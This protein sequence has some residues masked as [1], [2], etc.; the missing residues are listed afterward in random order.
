MK[1]SL[2]GGLLTSFLWFVATVMA[3]MQ[4]LE[5][6]AIWAVV[7][8]LLIALVFLYSKRASI[9]CISAQGKFNE[10]KTEEAFKLYDK[11]YATGNLKH[12]KALFYAYLL[13]RDGRLE[14]SE[15]IMDDVLKKYKT[16]LTKYDLLNIDI[17][18]ALIKWK[19]GDLKGAIACAE[20]IYNDGVKNT[21]LYGVL[22]YWYILDKRYDDALKINE[23]AYDYNANDQI[24]C[25][26]LAQNYF[27]VGQTDKSEE[28]YKNLLDKNPSFIEP[29][30]NYGILLKSKGDKEG[31][32][33]Y[34]EKAL[35]QKEKFLSTVTHNMVKEE[36]ESL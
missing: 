34:F 25:D 23:E 22:G 21:S 16:L 18:K 17:N 19:D 29:Y 2:L 5:F 30:F 32:K 6:G 33:E 11:A 27:L 1:N 14:K 31:A 8:F 26:N 3:F 35:L 36:L 13:L 24:I 28:M 7:V 12:G 10:G 9:M 4:A 20:K 15:K